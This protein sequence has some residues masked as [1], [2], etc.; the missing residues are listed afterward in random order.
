MN[1]KEV[2][3]LWIFLLILCF[4]KVTE[5]KGKSTIV[6]GKVLDEFG[7]P[8]DKATVECDECCVERTDVRVQT[9]QKGDFA[10]N[11]P[12][13]F[14]GRRVTLLVSKEGYMSYP[15]GGYEVPTDSGDLGTIKLDWLF[16][17]GKL[18]SKTTEKA[19]AGAIIRVPD[20]PSVQCTT[21][22]VGYFKKKSNLLSWLPSPGIRIKIDVDSRSYDTTC[23]MNDERNTIRLDV[24]PQ[25]KPIVEEDTDTAKKPPPSKLK[26]ALGFNIAFLVSDSAGD[27]IEGAEIGVDGIPYLGAFTDVKGKAMLKFGQDD[28]GK[29]VRIRIKKKG[30]KTWFTDERISKK[31]MTPLIEV[32]LEKHMPAP[33]LENPVNNDTLYAPSPTFVWESVAGYTYNLQVDDHSNFSDPEIDVDG[34]TAPHHKLGKKLRDGI[35]YWRVQKRE[36]ETGNYSQWSEPRIVTIK[37]LGPM[38]EKRKWKAAFRSLVLPGWGQKYKG[39]SRWEWGSMM[40]LYGSSIIGAIFADRIHDKE[41]EKYLEARSIEGIDDT[42]DKANLAHKIRNGLRIA[43]P[44]IA[45]LSA[46]HAYSSEDARIKEEIHAGITYDLNIR[47]GQIQLVFTKSF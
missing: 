20:E 23:L 46:I 11:I 2:L 4:G 10:L 45:I 32:T 43:I 29:V 36:T 26:V 3:L 5:A 44:A 33:K 16:I 31:D 39:H 18:I 25:K 28:T 24:A 22:S 30:Y 42:Y 15:R 34:L 7:N 21:N 37:D 1:I 17:A 12:S 13:E 40:V 9:D 6:K 35:Y 8:L 14:I 19:I 41:Y 47:K 27:P 38:K